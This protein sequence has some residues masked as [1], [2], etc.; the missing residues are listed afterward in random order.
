MLLNL[1]RTKVH[2][3]CSRTVEPILVLVFLGYLQGL[4]E[5]TRFDMAEG[6]KLW[7]AENGAVLSIK[8]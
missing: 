6:I 7:S 1:I 3:W 2:W 8:K 4:T 5:E